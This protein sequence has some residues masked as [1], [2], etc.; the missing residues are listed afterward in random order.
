MGDNIF[1]GDRD[2]VRTPMQWTMDRNGGFS[3]TDPA[4]LYL[5]PIMDPVYGFQTV[6]VEAQSRTPGSLLNWMRRVITVR[7]TRRVFG[8]GAFRLLYPSNRKIL[9]FLREQDDDTVLCVFN[10]ARTAQA[11][12]LDLAEF[13]GRTPVELFGR[14]EFP[15]IGELPYLLTLQGHSFFWFALDRHAPS[16]ISWHAP[17]AP[18][19]V[20]LVVPVGWPDLLDRHNKAQLE[21]DV[22]PPF[23]KRQRWFAGKDRT[24]AG[25]SLAA[26]DPF[27]DIENGVA[28]GLVDAT[29][30]DG[31][32]HRYALPLAA[33]WV[34]EPADRVANLR[35]FRRSGALV[36]APERFA[37]AA[38][39]RLERT[40]AWQDPPPAPTMR[41]IGAEQSNTSVLIEEYGVLKLYRHLHEGVHPEVEMTRFLMRR[42]FEATPAL[43]GTFERDGAV[44]AVLYQWL[45][46]QGEA[47]THALDYLRRFVEES[48]LEPADAPAPE[49]AEPAEQDSYYTTLARQLG[50]RAG[51]M[52]VALCPM[53]G[54]EPAFAPEPI[55]PEDVAGWKSALRAR[56]EELLPRIEQLSEPQ[57]QRL[58]QR[59]DALPGRIDAL[60][61]RYHGDF[62]LGQI[63]VVRNDFAIIDFEGEPLRPLAERRVKS[64]PLKDLAGML[65]SF[66]YVEATVVRELAELHAGRGDAVMRCA[67]AFRRRAVEAFLAGYDEATQGCPS[68]PR[69]PATRHALLDFFLIEKALYEVA[70]ERANRPTWL[71]I[72]VAGLIELLEESDAART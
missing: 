71:V 6:N 7:Q 3:R 37:L 68:I 16:R 22:L 60:K 47:W 51:E 61:T 70:Y 41:R 32:K 56:A 45:R 15:P 48:I 65:R 12:E 34:G 63:L 62:H 8:R 67:A 36:D 58:F 35:K 20:T 30:V 5:P 53:D 19:L 52:H 42:G 57:R 2:G 26:L 4:R 43:Y 21:R 59:I 39:P 29:F 27:G 69:D 11:V 66:H 49:V 33:D 17:P 54:A 14:S 13:S 1:L 24:V 64:S 50:R 23:L 55:T 9:A 46:N 40:P 10:L 31:T 38:L 18:E 44:V 28:L 72:P 25:V